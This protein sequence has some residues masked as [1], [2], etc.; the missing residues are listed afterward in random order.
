MLN[1]LYEKIKNFIIKNKIF[2]I[3]MIST[4]LISTIEFPYYIESPGGIIDISDKIDISTN[5]KNTGSLNLAYVTE[6]K[7]TIPTLIA[8]KFNKDWVINKSDTSDNNN[9]DENMYL[10]NHIMLDEANFNATKVALDKA[11][12]NYEIKEQ[13]LYVTYILS[14]AKT[15]LKVGDIITKINNQ[16]ITSK[17]ELKELL[18]NSNSDTVTFNVLRDNKEITCKAKWIMY[19]NKEVIGFALSEVG[20]IKTTSNIT[21]HFNK[22]ESG[23]S[24]GLMMSLALYNAL[25]NKDITHARKIVGTGTIDSE[26]NVGEI[27]GVPFKLKGAVKA[28]ADIFLAPAGKNYDEAIKLAK[29]NNYKIKIYSVSTFDEA[30]NIL[31]Q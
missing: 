11:N 12:I 21:F 23:P 29:E 14:E 1:K 30:L 9:T 13:K 7:A 17:N 8:A 25:T 24:G 22:N 20:K 28:H 26:G 3:I 5:Y 6:Y 19:D 16:N 27:D 31:E 10:R 18:N 4:I 2:I 15:D